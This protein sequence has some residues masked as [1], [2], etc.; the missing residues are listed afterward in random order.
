MLGSGIESG[1]T[2]RLTRGGVP[3]IVGSEIT[4]APDGSSLAATFDLNG[5]V[6]GVRNVVVTNPD[7]GV[8][9][10]TGGF[11]V[12]G[13]AAPQL[14]VHV[15]GPP[16]IRA[17]RL[18]SFDI[19]IVNP[20]NVDALDVPL[21][22]TGV[23]VDATFAIDFTLT[24]PPQAGG[25]PDWSL[26]PLTFTSPGGQYLPVVIPRVPPGTTTRRVFLTVPAADP[27]F[28]LRAAVTPPWIDGNV[29]R[30]CLAASGLI[31][32]PSCMGAQL[33]A[34]NSFLALDPS[35]AA[36]SGIGVWAKIAWQCEGAATLPAALVKAEQVLDFMVMPVEQPG[37]AIV[38]CS[39]VL[40]PRWRDSLLVTIV[41]SFDPNEKL[42]ARDTIS[43]QQPIPYS[44]RFENASI[45]TA[46]AQNVVISDPLDMLRLDPSTVSLDVITFGNVHIVPPPGLSSFATQ[47]DLR[48]ARDLL[49]NANAAV[50]PFTGVVTW[51]F[52][53]IDPA[54]GQTPPLIGF[55]PP[56]VNPPEGEGSVLFTVMPRPG[57]SS[58]TQISNA[59]TITFDGG[60]PH[61]TG[62]V[63]NTV[64]NT[65]PSSHVQ[66]LPVSS[67]QPSIPVQWTADGAPLGLKDFTVYVAEDGASY[68]VWRLNIAS[69]T[70][71]L[72]PPTDHHFH[73]YAFYSVARDQSGNVE[74]PPPGP[75]A[76]T[77]SRTAVGDAGP[78]QLAL[79]GARPNPAFG[80]LRVW[81]T[82]PNRDA[83][84]LEM[85][86]VAGRR[87]IRREVGSL[88]AGPHS[89]TL[90]SSPPLRPGLYFLRLAQ[91][92]HVLRARVA[93][94]R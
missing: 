87:V 61:T 38:S 5:A 22:I 8:A 54:T 57:L 26:V 1:A 91:Q 19:V 21:W 55:L 39:N 46:D 12:S 58:G 49:V 23:P 92:T 69:L 35:I 90:E 45:A 43:G 37:T 3:D 75:D 40:P 85:L 78:W 53:S 15:I 70:D 17:N 74:A 4:V 6:M 77:Q 84:S 56:N 51:Y 9:T 31:T 60:A 89:V 66:P 48:P 79:E 10:L 33:T 20:G 63:V 27:T 76:T 86:D 80:A 11:T 44:I 2:V 88:G 32:A 64:D 24:P 59:A 28:T 25:E 30:G 14:S 7:L 36:L 47:V 83:A 29:F 72:A 65:P 93:L 42:G 34:I 13:V 41:D 50:D 73:N 62:S 16:K 67:D 18:S 68:R 81:F 94:I 71:T 82:L 52:S